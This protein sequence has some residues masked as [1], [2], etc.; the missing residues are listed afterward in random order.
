VLA[1]LARNARNPKFALVGKE[2]ETCKKMAWLNV[3]V[4]A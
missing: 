1:R 4:K 2:F 3:D